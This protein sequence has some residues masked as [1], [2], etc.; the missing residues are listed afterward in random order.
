VKDVPVRATSRVKRVPALFGAAALV[1]AT[2]AGC[3]AIPGFGGCDPRYDG[4]EASTIVTASGSVGS[5]PTVDF[6]TPLVAGSGTEVST[7]VEGEGREIGSGDQVDYAFAIFDGE[8]G[9]ALGTSGFGDAQASRVASGLDDNAVSGALECLAVGSRAVVVTTWEQA[10]AA[11]ST[12]AEG[13]IDDTATVVVV[14]DVIDA[15]LGK[16]DGINQLPADGMPTVATQVDGTPGISV[17]LQDAPATTRSSVIK[18]GDGRTLEAGDQAV[19]MYSLWTWPA[20][21]GDDPAQIG[22]TWAA[23]RAVTLAL[24]DIA[25]GGGLPTGLLEALVGEKIGSQVLVVLPPGDDSFPAG[26]GPSSDDSTYVFV[27]DLLGIQE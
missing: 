12:D 5:E 22:T 15:Y 13:Q 1:T 20:A 7:L 3:T 27:V 8:S 11:F 19:V 24:T 25:D 26:Q 17:L 9:E 14:L 4:G 21:A 2:L 10:K 23:H 16:A 18:G 6:P